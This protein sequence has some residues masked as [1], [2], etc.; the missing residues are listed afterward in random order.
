MLMDVRF[1]RVGGPRECTQA[2]LPDGSC[3]RLSRGIC[4][5]AEGV[6][7]LAARAS[8]ANGENE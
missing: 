4:T 6:R 2:G 7:A 5:S 1:L 8:G 3:R